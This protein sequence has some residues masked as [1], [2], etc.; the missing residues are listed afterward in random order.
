MNL[1]K[2]RERE[3][4]KERQSEGKER[5]KEEWSGCQLLCDGVPAFGAEHRCQH[6]KA[7]L[8][9]AR[10]EKPQCTLDRRMCQGYVTAFRRLPHAT[11]PQ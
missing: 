5:R 4:E 11:G 1:G 6:V 9:G 3:R 10:A 2:E 7:R 8:L